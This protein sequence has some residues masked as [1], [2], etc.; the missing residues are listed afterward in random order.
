MDTII[1]WV[2]HAESCANLMD[3]KI[4]DKYLNNTDITLYNDFIKQILTEE[5][6]NYKKEPF[7]TDIVNANKKLNKIINENKEKISKSKIKAFQK[8]CSN[9]KTT[10]NDCWLATI[11]TYPDSDIAKAIFSKTMINPTWLYHPTLS[12]IGI[13]QALGLGKNHYFKKYIIANKNIFITSASVRTIMTAL[14]SLINQN[15][16]Y[17]NVSLI[18]APFINEHESPAQIIDS[19]RANHGIS[20]DKIVSIVKTV[21]TW[22]KKTGIINTSDKIINIDTQFYIET[23]RTFR[24]YNPLVSNINNFT[25]YILPILEA[26][27]SDKKQNANIIAYSHG[28]VITSLLKKYTTSYKQQYHPNVSIFRELLLT[29]KM[30]NIFNGITIRTQFEDAGENKD[31]N[32]CNLSSLRGDINKM[33]IDVPKST[34]TRTSKTHKSRKSRKSRKSQSHKSRKSQSHKSRKTQSR[35]SQSRKQAY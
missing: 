27:S 34:F 6:N 19:D 25:K 12:Y 24:D 8:L 16:D 7:K 28:Y 14:L 20:P 11:N 4:T 26:K 33:L 5:D 30:E 15:L 13:Q 23:C 32:L 10:Q 21:L 31:T 1:D 35:K 22:L 2:R 3:N 9:V 18:I 29:K 17:K